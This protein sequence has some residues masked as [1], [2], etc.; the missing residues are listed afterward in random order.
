VHE[1]SLE[2]V[3]GA[4]LQREAGFVAASLSS[5]SLNESAWNYLRGLARAHPEL[6][7]E[8]KQLAIDA[9]AASGSSNSFAVALL[10]DLR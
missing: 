7:P 9:V 5:V 1:N 6:L 3:S 4:V 8:A 2:G 10:A